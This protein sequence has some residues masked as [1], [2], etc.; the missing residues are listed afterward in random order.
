MSKGF[1]CG[2]CKA[3]FET[4]EELRLHQQLGHLK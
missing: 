2:I 4:R 1:K 3:V